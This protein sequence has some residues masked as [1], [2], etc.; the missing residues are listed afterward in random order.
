MLSFVLLEV[1]KHDQYDL[2]LPTLIQSK[3]FIT[4]TDLL[5]L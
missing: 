1:T 2:E 4:V 3:P 5:V